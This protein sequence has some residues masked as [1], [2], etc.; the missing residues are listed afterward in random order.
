MSCE[1]SRHQVASTARFL[2]GI[3][4]FAK[5]CIFKQ[6]RHDWLWFFRF[7]LFLFH[8]FL[9]FLLVKFVDLLNKVLLQGLRKL[10]RY[11]NFI[12]FFLISRWQ[13]LF[14]R[15]F[16]SFVCRLH[17]ILKHL[18]VF[19]LRHCRLVDNPRLLD[20]WLVLDLADWVE[21]LWLVVTATSVFTE[22]GRIHG[23]LIPRVR[24]LGKADSLDWGW[25][26][27]W[28][29]L[30]ALQLFILRLGHWEAWRIWVDEGWSIHFE[31]NFILLQSSLVNCDVSTY[32]SRTVFLDD[33]SLWVESNFWQWLAIQLLNC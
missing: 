32:F 28:F 1:F 6:L 30:Y 24:L 20:P 13:G 11:D 19:N 17:G 18:R 8:L 27:V 16:A 33:L 14:G 2:L 26:T 25:W 10:S 31:H 22:H 9:F 15:I 5:D 29:S 23:L 12:F 4:Y 3:H 21:C 7:L